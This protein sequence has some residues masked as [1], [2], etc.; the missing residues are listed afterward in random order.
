[1][2]SLVQYLLL[3]RLGDFA[4]AINVLEKAQGKVLPGGFFGRQFARLAG[5]VAGSPGGVGGSIIGNITGG[6]LADI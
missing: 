1:L 5:T 2:I 4:S 3:Q 6:V